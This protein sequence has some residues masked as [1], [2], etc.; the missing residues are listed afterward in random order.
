ME[1]G[2]GMEARVVVVEQDIVRIR[3]AVDRDSKAV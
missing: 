1:L 2:G 3:E